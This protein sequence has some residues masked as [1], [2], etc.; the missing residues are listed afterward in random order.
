MKF[1]HVTMASRSSS[2]EKQKQAKADLNGL[3]L[4]AYSDTFAGAKRTLAFA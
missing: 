4:L 2:D 3:S 1:F